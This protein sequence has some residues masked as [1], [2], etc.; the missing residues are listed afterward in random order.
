VLKAIKIRLYPTDNQQLYINKLIGSSRYVYNQCLN[1]KIIEYSLWNNTTGIK[2]TGKHL[3]E[4]K[5]EKEWLKE[6]HSKVLQQS[7]INLETAYKNFFKSGS[8]FPKFKSRHQNQSCRFPVD[9]ISGVK[10]NRINIINALKDI[11]Y[12]C[13][14]NDE[15][16]L[17]KNQDLIKSGTLSKTKSGNYYFSILIDKPNKTIKKTANHIVGIDLGIKDFIVSSEGTRYENLKSKRLNQN[18]LVRLHREL[19]RKVKGSNKRNKARIRLAKTYEKLNNIKE[20]YLHSVIN[21]LLSENQTIVMEDLN[22]KG[23]LKNHKLAKSI[24]ELSL[25]RFKTILRY[26]AEWYGREVIEV[27]KWFPSSKLCGACGYKNQ[28]LELKDRTWVC[29]ECGV[30][31]DR[32]L[33]AAMNIRNEGIRIKIGLSSPELTPQEGKPE[34]PRRMRKENVKKLECH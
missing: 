28:E 32:D 23:M 17:N 4:L 29:P 6:S 8:G 27:S 26:K 18:K 25:N 20:Y 30:V 31:H 15:K 12:K 16:Y 3:T 14:S 34:G 1:Y 19:S 22:V 21:Q 24:Q 10:G 13:S 33:N 11:H 7:L 2:D 5:Q 9:A